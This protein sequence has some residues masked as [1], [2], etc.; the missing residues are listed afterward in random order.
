MIDNNRKQKINAFL[1]RI[2]WIAQSYNYDYETLHRVVYNE[3]HNIG[4]DNLNCDIS[5][6]FPYWINNNQRSTTSVFQT[7]KHKYFCQFVR[8]EYQSQVIKESDPVKLYIPVNASHLY[9]AV[10]RIFDFCDA[11]NIIHTSKVAKEIRNDNIVLRVRTKEDAIKII[12]Y[13]SSDPYILEGRLE[14]NPFCISANGVGLAVDNYNSYNMQ[15][16]SFIANYTL[17]NKNNNLTYK[18]SIEDFSR[19]VERTK[20]SYKDHQE[21]IYKEEIRGLIVKSLNS[22]DV[23]TLFDHHS[24]VSSNAKSNEKQNGNEDEYMTI[25]NRLG[26][27]LNVTMEN[28]GVEFAKQ[29]LREYLQFGS[30]SGF[31]K[32]AKDNGVPDTTL[33]YR[34]MMSSYNPDYVKRILFSYSKTTDIEEIVNNYFYNGD[35]RSDSSIAR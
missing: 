25:L 5:Y 19:F 2:E 6:M 32:Y 30:L 31:S 15:V 17:F 24:K 18:T 1:K 26:S 11:N 34:G 35:N 22:S 10:N 29:A 27:A 20:P 21:E 14:V 16:A 4:V 7:E 12:N 13:V 9:E 28:H 3:L 23:N 33:N 8:E